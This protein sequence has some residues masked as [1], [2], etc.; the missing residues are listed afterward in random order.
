MDRKGIDNHLG[1]FGRRLKAK[2]HSRSCFV[3][4]KYLPAQSRMN[5]GRHFIE[6]VFEQARNEKCRAIPVIG[7]SNGPSSLKATAAVIQSDQ[8]GVALRLKISDFDRPNLAADIEK[9]L[10]TLGVSYIEADLIVDKGTMNLITKIIIALID[11]IPM[12]NRW[13]TF[14]ITGT[15][16]PASVAGLESPFQEIPRQEWIA[17]RALV[18]RI[19]SGARIP[20]FGDYAVAHPDPVEL[21]MRIVK[22]FAKLRYTFKNH[23][24]I[25]RGAPVRTKGFEQYRRLCKTLMNQEY[26]DGLGYSAGDDYI[27]GCA[28]GEEPTG[29]LTTWVW[30]S[31]NRHL[32]KVVND[33]ATFHGLSDTAE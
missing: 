29:N 12:L 32:T 10:K 11:M 13:R 16:Y 4:T 19:G 5:D 31:T 3:D 18:N 1:D 28:G 22:P 27:A 20:T 26:F 24:H 30:V 33:L 8:R 7:L 15:S 14:T 21:D 23:W 2:W 6:E 9:I 25:G 17:Y